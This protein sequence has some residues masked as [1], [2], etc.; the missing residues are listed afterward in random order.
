MDTQPA[1]ATAPE[2]PTDEPRRPARGVW[3]AIA[4]AIVVVAVVALVLVGRSG[5]SHPTGTQALTG[6]NP[7]VMTADPLG[8][9]LPGGTFAR[10]SDGDTTFSAYRGQALVVNFWSATCIPCRTEMPSLEKLHEQLGQRVTFV[11]VDSGDATPLARSTARQLGARYTIALD[12]TQ[13]I[14]RA[15]GSVGLPTTLVVSPAGLVTYIHIGA[16]D[17][18]QLRRQ[19]DQVAR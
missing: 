17:I 13:R 8:K 15:V 11:G 16:V 14:I 7:L 19:I 3:L 12:P 2:P 9:P 4:V 5:S 10:L 1:P 6:S 18:A